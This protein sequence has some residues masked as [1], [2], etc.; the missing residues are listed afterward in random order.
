MELQ[1]GGQGSFVYDGWDTLYSQG[2]SERETWNLPPWLYA[3]IDGK[4]VYFMVVCF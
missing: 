4:F 2:V 3:C 1:V